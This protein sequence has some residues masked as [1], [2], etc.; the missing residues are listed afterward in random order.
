MGEYSMVLHKLRWNLKEHGMRGVLEKLF[1]EVSREIFHGSEYLFHLDLSHLPE[2]ACPLPPNIRIDTFSRREDLPEGMLEHMKEFV[3]K[4][5]MREEHEKRYVE[6]LFRLFEDGGN[7]HVVFA[8]NRP[9]AYLWSISK[10]NIAS[11]FSFFPFLPEDGL[12]I[13]GNTLARYRGQGML[14]LLMRHG[15]Y[16]LKTNGKKRAYGACKTWNTPS[17]KGI[18]KSGFKDFAIA[19]RIRIFGRH[20]VIWPINRPRA[21]AMTDER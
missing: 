18:T 7:I 4:K 5:G 9:A 14:P 21:G 3:R 2:N 6:I 12:L 1:R 10:G 11:H 15:A 13:G 20:I 17:F 19:R 8:D 16:W